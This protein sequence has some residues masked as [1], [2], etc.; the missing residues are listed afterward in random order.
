[1]AVLASLPNALG[2]ICS[3]PQTRHDTT[4]LQVGGQKF[5]AILA[6][7]TRKRRRRGDER[8]QERR[9]E[10]RPTAIHPVSRLLILCKYK[11]KC[12]SSRLPSTH[13]KRFTTNSDSS[14]RGSNTLYWLP[15]ASTHK[16]H[17]NK[18]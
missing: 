3:T 16:A 15:W 5:K 1:L 2:A 9:G 6:T 10:E 11:E 18:N 7:L 12:F 8:G 13:I 17:M 4:C 14:S